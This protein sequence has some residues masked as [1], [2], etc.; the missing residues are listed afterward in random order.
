MDVLKEEHVAVW[1]RFHPPGPNPAGAQQL[2]AAAWVPS[3]SAQDPEPER[4]SSDEEWMPRT[5]LIAKSTYVWLDQLSKTYR[6]PITRLDEIPD[7]ELDTLA[8]RGF[9][10]LWLIG[11]WE[12]SRASKRIKQ[13]MGKE[14]AVASAYSLHDY[15]IAADLGGPPAYEHLRDRAWKRGIRLASDM[16]ANHMGID[17]RWVMQHPD[18]FLQLPYSPFP[19]YK[20]EGPN[21]SD[22]DRIEIKIDDRYYEKSDAAVVFRRVDRWTG[23][24]R[25]IYHGNDGTSFPWNDTAQLDFLKA[26]VREGVIQT[27]LHVARQFPIIRFD[28]AMTLAKRH[29]QRLWFPEPGHGGAIPSRAEHGLTKAA[30]DAAIPVEFWREVV[31]R[32]AAEAPGTLL[33][34]EAFWLMEGYFVRTLG[35]HRVYNSAFMVMLRDEDNGK[36]RLVIKNTLE[37]DPEILKRYVNFLNNPDERTAVDQFGNGDKYFGVT[38]MMSTMPGLPMFGHGQVE[39]FTERY[40]MEYRRAYYDEHPDVE[41]VA[42]HDRQI[43][44]LLHRRALFAEAYDFRLYDFY[45]DDGWVNEDVF[46]YSNRRGD[47]RALVVYHNRYAQTRGWVR[48]SCAYSEKA[49][50][51][52]P[53]LVQ[54]TLGEALG[55]SRNEATFMVYRDAL[56]GLE[57]IHS[58]RALADE[59]MHL[60]LEAYTCHVFVDWR[61][62]VDD[63]V[64]PW[65]RLAEYLDGR[66]VSSVDEAFLLML[67]APLHESLRAL[68]DPALVASLAASSRAQDADGVAP[69][70]VAGERLRAFL[71]EARDV[72][73]RTASM[74]DT[75]ITG[76]VDR[77]VRTFEERLGAASRLGGL[78]ERL[79]A[80]W[81]P[82][83]VPAA[84]TP[85]T[86]GAIVAWSAL[87]AL[88]RMCNP[89]DPGDAAARMFERLRL[90]GVVASA[91]ERLG[92]E[93]EDRWRVA[94]RVRLALAHVRPSR[95]VPSTAAFAPARSTA[96]DVLQDP[97]AAWLAGVHEYDGVRYF[98]KEPFERLVWW[99]ALPALLTL[100]ADGAPSREALR[101]LERELGARMEAAEAGGYRVPEGAAAKT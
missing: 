35:M 87:E 71:V 64:R 31:D 8:R 75:E 78:E 43:A 100:A 20:F 40:G 36:Y 101:A 54:Q 61:E 90:R 3:Y 69:T 37:F 11:L 42:R 29:F 16:V 44:P 63:G 73:T 9:S 17:S 46:A 92:V 68:L 91:V 28:A 65:R 66:G 56:S 23:D 59:G 49:A 88:G 60:S 98:V 12:R 24:T 50:P 52:G 51:G 5:V 25:F 74:A 13:L 79:E 10:A 15:V 72:C 85:A 80:R 48:T 47:E 32:V 97:D 83:T 57:Y 19:V 55:L 14:D 67:L 62:V 89:A 76:D 22:D 18:W 45:T 2:E 53:R 26:E 41:M 38:V 1:L 86:L 77:A 99:M 70:T 93:G 81:S 30:F 96:L 94:A 7:E 4:F 21:L 33:L 6:R 27:I 82:G 84:D 34:A 58:S 95:S 39:G